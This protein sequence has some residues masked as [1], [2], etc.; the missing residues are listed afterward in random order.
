TCDSDQ[1]DRELVAANVLKKAPKKLTYAVDA[2]LG[3][4]VSYLGADV[5]VAQKDGHLDVTVTHYWKVVQPPG[6]GWQ[7]RTDFVLGWT[8][9]RSEVH[10]GPETDM[11]RV[12]P[13]ERWRVG[14][15][16][17]DAETMRLDRDGAAALTIVVSLT[18]ESSGAK[19]PVARG[20]TDDHD[21]VIAAAIPL[22]E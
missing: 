21:G 22:G 7:P 20:P 14:D 6:A 16:I 18:E 5:D 12:Y 2:D 1:R 15:V 9:G 8:S 3:G 19:M 13:S 17:R 10:P 11:S 4:Q